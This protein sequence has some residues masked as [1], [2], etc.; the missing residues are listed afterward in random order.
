MNILLWTL[1]IL[2]A[3]HT[4]MGAVWKFSNSVEKTMPSLKA[5]PNGLWQAMGGFEI[6]GSI[7][8]VVPL[9]YM[10]LDFLAPAAA[11]CIAAE[12]LIFIVLHYFSGDSTFGPMIYW[13]MVA[14]VCG[15]IAYGRLVLVG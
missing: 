11:I 6:L 8:L 1:Q 7:A 3:L 4:L 14:V 12:M 2:L 15:F 9:F 5:I 13:I 10:P